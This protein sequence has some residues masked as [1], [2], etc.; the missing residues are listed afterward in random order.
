VVHAKDTFVSSDFSVT[1]PDGDSAPV[2]FLDISPAGANDPVLVDSHLEWVTTLGDMGDHII[3]LVATDPCGLADTCQFS[4]FVDEPTG[5][6]SCPDDDSVHAGDLFVSTNFVLTYPECDPS[7]VEILDITPVP[8]HNPV[9]VDYHVE[10]LTTCAEQGDY[11]IRLR[12]N[13][14]CS[15]EDTCSFTVTVYNRP[16]ELTCPDYGHVEP[17]GLFISTDFHVSDPDGDEA[18]VV[19]LGIDPPAEH[20]PVIVEHHVEW[21]TECVLGDYIITLAAT[22]PCGLADTCEFMVTVS[23]DPLPDFTIWVYPLDQYVA[24]GHTAGY[25][26]ELN[27]LN[28]FA[29]PCTLMVSGLPAPPDHGVFD[30]AVLTPVDTTILTVYTT[31]ATPQGY[32][33]L[34]VTGKQ[35]SGSIQHSVQVGLT[36]EEPSDVEDLPDQSNR[37]GTFSLFQNQPNPFNPETQIGYLLPTDCRA[38]LVIYNVL[39]RTV[40]TLV[41][42]YQNAGMHNLRWDGRADDGTQLSSGIYFYRLKAGNFDHTRKMVLMK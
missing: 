42:E 32:Y 17:L 3:R 16:P 20:D 13:E 18:V 11:I 37:P 4:V 41:D 9:L 36:V 2:V 14:T 21:L 29:F 7:S 1:D 27:S 35:K 19:L 26:V 28:G 6:F 22:D 30:R 34:T 33:T 39:G 25:L 10:W 24:A 15:T 23:E 8:T 31:A 40:R 12:T 38:Q 5:D